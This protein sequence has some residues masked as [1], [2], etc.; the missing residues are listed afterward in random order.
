MINEFNELNKFQ[1]SVSERGQQI[2]GPIYDSVLWNSRQLATK[3]DIQFGSL[4]SYIAISISSN[5]IKV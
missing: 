1:S 4:Q 5:Y 3:R 2:H